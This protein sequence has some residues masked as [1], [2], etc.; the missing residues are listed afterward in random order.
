LK[1]KIISIHGN[2]ITQHGCLLLE[3]GSYAVA[4]INMWYALNYGMCPS[5]EI[6]DVIVNGYV[7]A[8]ILNPV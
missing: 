7:Y 3:E 5:R 8:K 4:A 6:H 2:G 1:D